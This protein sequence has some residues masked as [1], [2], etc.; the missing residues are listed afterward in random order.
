MHNAVFRVLRRP[1]QLSILQVLLRKFQF[2]RPCCRPPSGL[3][4]RHVA[5]YVLSGRGEPVGVQF[6][7]AQRHYSNFARAQ[8]SIAPATSCVV[9]EPIFKSVIFARI[10]ARIEVN[11]VLATS[12]VGFE[13]VFKSVL[14]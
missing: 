11:I 4:N 2:D 7:C 10:R 3:R 6:L 12:F 5:F 14:Y 8:V 13:P 9:F 1:Q